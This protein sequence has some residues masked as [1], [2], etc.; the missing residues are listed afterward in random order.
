MKILVVED[1]VE[2]LEFVKK[3]FLRR[4][5]QLIPV[6]MDRKGCLWLALPITT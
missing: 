2:T 5:I 3:G 1:D 6:L 4:G